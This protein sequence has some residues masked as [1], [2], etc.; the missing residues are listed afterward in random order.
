MRRRK[1]INHAQLSKP[2]NSQ[3]ERGKKKKKNK[4]YSNQQGK[5]PTKCV[6]ISKHL[7]ITALM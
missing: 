5:E 3:E 2:A 7:S 1:R 4:Q 6:G